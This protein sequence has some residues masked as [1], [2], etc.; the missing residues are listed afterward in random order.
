MN[1]SSIFLEKLNQDLL[2]IVGI[3]L[4]TA[5]ITWL[6]AS[7]YWYQKSKKAQNQAIKK[8]RSVI[9]G[10]ITEQIAPLLKNFPFNPKDM[11]FLGKWVDYIIIKDLHKG[12]PS[13]I[14]FLEIKTG[15]S[16]LNQNELK[17]KRLVDTK[18]IEYRLI[19]L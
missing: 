12:N 17:I 1:I 6:F 10:Q 5:I 18:K 16:Q 4:T 19:R 3:T 11:V 7:I 9:I 2:L 8:S 15:Q 14:I 13:K